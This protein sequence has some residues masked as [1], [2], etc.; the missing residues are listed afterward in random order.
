MKFSIAF[1]VLATTAL[2]STTLFAQKKKESKG[3]E[4]T[5]DIMLD[6]S[7]IKNQEITGTCWSF[8][9]TSFLESEYERINGK[10]I[11]L[12]EMYFVRRMYEQKS[13]NYVLRQGAAQFSQGGLNHDVLWALDEFGAMPQSA[14]SGNNTNLDYHNHSEMEAVLKGALDAVVSNPNRSLTTS[15]PVAINGILDAYMGS[16]PSEFEYN[17][18]TSNPIDFGN[19]LGLNASEYRSFTSFSHHDFGTEFILE[20]PDNWRNGSFM[21]VE[22]DQMMTII[23]NALENGYT[24]AWDADV[25][26]KM[27]STKHGVAIWPSKTYRELNDEE[28]DQ[29]F[30]KPLEEADVDQEMRQ[31]A[32]ENYQTTDDHLMHIV[33]IAY[34]QHGSKYYVVKNS[35]GTARGID[36]YIYV[37]VGYMRMKTISV[38]VHQD[39][40]N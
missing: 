28:K 14:Y 32:F 7:E 10:S 26:E 20:I 22:L 18:T 9:T 17:G 37:S 24:L 1:G 15:W 21:N 5:N 6:H 3:F 33:G 39:A 40:L 13:R 23:D 2:F 29:L 25:S 16:V 30:L 36:G 35:W 11:D 4:F 12:S 34:D 27:W 8:S 38:T 31:E 19:T